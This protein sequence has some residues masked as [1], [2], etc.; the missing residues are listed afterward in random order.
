MY[1]SQVEEVITATTNDMYGDLG[2]EKRNLSDQTG[3]TGFSPPKTASLN[4]LTIRESFFSDLLA[5]LELMQVVN[6]KIASSP[7][8][9]SSLSN[10]SNCLDVLAPRI[11]EL[12]NLR[13]FVVTAVTLDPPPLVRASTNKSWLI[14]SCLFCVPTF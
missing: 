3:A 13:R 10:L 9:S 12:R 14:Q 5:S 1:L 8:L 6:N 2:M 11:E 7:S 4:K